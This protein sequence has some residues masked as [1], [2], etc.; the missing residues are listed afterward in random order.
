M[1]ARQKERL[2]VY[3]PT[4]EVDD[5][6]AERIVWNERGTYWAERSKRQDN[7]SVEVGECF[8]NAVTEWNVNY[9]LSGCFEANWRLADVRDGGTL[10][11][12]K[13][14]TPNRDKGMMTISCERVNE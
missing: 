13:G 10:Y 7:L 9:A 1:K 11:L 2:T 6:G 4:V 12:I 3:E 14:K 5:Y 8:P